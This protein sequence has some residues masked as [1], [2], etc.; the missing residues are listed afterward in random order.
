MYADIP[1]KDQ[2]HRDSMHHPIVGAARR[3]AQ[4]VDDLLDKHHQCFTSM[5]KRN[6]L[7]DL[8]R[9]LVKWEASDRLV[10][11]LQAF[12]DLKDI[13]AKKLGTGAAPAQRHQ[14]VLC[15]GYVTNTAIPP[16]APSK[17]RDPEKADRQQMVG[18]CE[19]MARAV[20]AASGAAT[21]ILQG[22]PAHETLKI[23]MA[24]EFYFRASHWA[25]SPAVVSEI[26][27][28]MHK[29]IPKGCGDWLFILGTAV[30]AW[31]R[32]D[33]RAEVYNT[34][35]VLRGNKAHL[36]AKEYVS[37]IDYKPGQRPGE[38]YG[39]VQVKVGRELL[40]LAVRPTAGSR[41]NDPAPPPPPLGVPPPPPA[42]AP[43]ER[44]GGGIFTIDGITF[45]LEVCLDHGEE[46]LKNQGVIQVQLIPSCGMNI[47]Y[48]HQNRIIFNVD[49]GAH[50]GARVYAR[51]LYGIPATEMPGKTGKVQ[52]FGPFRLPWPD[53]NL[54]G[55]WEEVV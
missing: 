30:A 34:A 10:R 22:R 12:K 9:A 37:N 47:A 2:W 26:L 35:L 18:Q 50:L 20:G 39:L 24:P 38:A 46:R 27:P 52:V 8:Q 54:V 33:G 25:Y 1:T 19:R 16:P 3:I 6:I 48:P 41:Q 17:W 13:T 31:Q 36:V 5:A 55:E 14:N 32:P 15:M 40:E 42:P 51:R 21:A 11:S 29:L 44:M 43:D 7:N 45:G 28:T 23:F 49:G 53:S 4:S